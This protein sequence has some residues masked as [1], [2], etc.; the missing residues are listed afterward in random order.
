MGGPG[1]NRTATDA[2]GLSVKSNHGGV[3]NKHPYK[4]VSESSGSVTSR[5]SPAFGR[6]DGNKDL[7]PAHRDKNAIPVEY[8]ELRDLKQISDFLGFGGWA[9]ARGV[10]PPAFLFITHTVHS[11]PRYLSSL[12][13]LPGCPVCLRFLP[14]NCFA[15]EPV[16]LVT[17]PTYVH[18]IPATAPLC[19]K[20]YYSAA[21]ITHHMIIQ[22]CHLCLFP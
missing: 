1:K 7:V 14:S 10:S 21:L 5:S 13:L 3:T 11:H 9:C 20:A 15:P 2:S 16:Y 12:L 6:Y 22:T 8:M 19:N 4:V 17:H 18:S